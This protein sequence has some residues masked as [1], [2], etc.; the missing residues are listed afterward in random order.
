MSED[1]S[2]TDYKFVVSFALSRGHL[3]SMRSYADDDRSFQ[4]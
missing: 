3:E 4:R 2:L 1:K